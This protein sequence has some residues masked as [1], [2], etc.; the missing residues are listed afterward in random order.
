MCLY[1]HKITLERYRR[2]HNR[3]SGNWN[4]GDKQQH[5]QAEVYK[6][7]TSLRKRAYIYDYQIS[8]GLERGPWQGR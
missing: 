3:E 1:T 4:D 5:N 2:D 8:S 6:T 7:S